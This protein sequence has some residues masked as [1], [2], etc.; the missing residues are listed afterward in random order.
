MDNVSAG[1]DMRGGARARRHRMRDAAR[2]HAS[3]AAPDHYQTPEWL[4]RSFVLPLTRLEAGPENGPGTR[5]EISDLPQQT[6]PHHDDHHPGH[7]Q[8]VH[9]EPGMI[10]RLL[11]DDAT[12]PARPFVRPPTEQ[13]DFGLVVQRADLARTA[14]RLSRLAVGLA[15]L[16]LV[17][18]LL[19]SS[20]V[21]LGVV[22]V[23]ALAALVALT[24]H[25]RLTTAPVPRLR[26]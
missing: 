20:V 22:V 11:H 19:L 21:L 9:R 25:L 24:V 6:R 2:S 1:E 15:G 13:I 14:A 5:T 16:C 18:Y 26:T 8:D 7:H 3:P 17:A 10:D 4:E 12:P 23:F